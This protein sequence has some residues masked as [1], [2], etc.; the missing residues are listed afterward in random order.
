[1]S[2]MPPRVAAAFVLAIGATSPCA[3]AQGAGT[4]PAGPLPG[5]GALP[6]NFAVPRAEQDPA[7]RLLQEQR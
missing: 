4:L 3:V 2:R 5:V 7:Q 1:M 6:P